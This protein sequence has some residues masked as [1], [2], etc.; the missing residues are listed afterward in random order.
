MAQ[1]YTVGFP[2]DELRSDLR[3]IY[4]PDGRPLSIEV[5]SKVK[6][7]FG[8]ALRKQA[9]AVCKD[10]AVE[11]GALVLEDFGALPFVVAARI[12][13]VLKEAHPKTKGEHLPHMEEECTYSSTRDRLRR[14]RL[15]IP[16]NQPKLMLNAGVHRP[17]GIILDMEDSVAPQHKPATRYLVRNALRTLDF[18]EA[19]RMV[20]I[21]QGELGLADLSYVVPH[22]VHLILL[23][24]VESGEQVVAVDERI[25][26]ISSDCG[27]EDPVFLMPIIESARGILKALEIAESSPNIVALTIGLEDYTAD[28]GTERTQD[29]RESFFARSM[30]VTAARA[31]GVQAIDTVYSDV[32]NMEGLTASV[33]EAKSLGFDGKGCIHP[34]QIQP[35]HDGFAP[36]NREIEKAKKIVRAFDDAQTRGLGV[37]SLGSK[38][39]DPPVVKRAHHTIE[40]AV[41]TGHLSPDWKDQES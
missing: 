20:R 32:A 11:T 21:N 2:G 15:Y 9:E 31:A 35:I 27:R 17:D 26:E 22:N 25:R 30:I 29:G 13:A 38:M 23:P 16:G 37:V 7:M 19:E 33:L 40:T 14:S 28:I 10:L 8:E 36:S 6:A 34:R 4:T 12:E 39:I 41:A 5:R 1:S 3:A 18:L 24:K